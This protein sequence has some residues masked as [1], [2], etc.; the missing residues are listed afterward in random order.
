M[1]RIIF[2]PQYPSTM[3]YQEWWAT[4]FPKEFEKRGFE[5]IVLGQKYIDNMK[6]PHDPKYFSPLKS[7]IA[8][9]TDQIN[10]YMRLEL[11]DD[12]ILLLNDISY[13]GLFANVLFHKRP[14]KCFAFC[15]ATS[16]N[17]MDYFEK[18]RTQKFP[19]ET[20]LSQ[21]FNKVFVGS[22]YHQ[23][24]L[25]W[26][27]T[28]VTYLPLPP[29]DCIKT[30]LKR[31]DIISVSRV[32]PQ[33]VDLALEN[34]IEEKAFLKI[35]RPISNTWGQYFYNLSISRILLI[36]AS[37]DTFGYQIVDAILNG[38]IPLARNNFAYPELLDRK[39]L[40]DNEKEL[41]FKINY[42]LNNQIRTV[43]SILC[44]EQMKN[45]YNTICNS[46]VGE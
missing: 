23:E 3:R 42:I 14:K 13:P 36:T 15:H 4:E 12:D 1:A 41:L 27:N 32:T 39:F 9:E 44:L 30:D 37:E 38:C 29:F 25:G 33:K 21:L 8:M 45:F 26:K 43:P 46:F 6:C 31:Y 24:K 20:S 11:K 18:D 35:F 10:E 7:S 2:I 22:K 34:D 40:Y 16:L 28:I 5:C 19:I 17:T